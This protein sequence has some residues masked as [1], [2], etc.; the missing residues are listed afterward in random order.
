MTG[1]G[2]MHALESRLLLWAASAGA[3]RATAPGWLP[4]R[5]GTHAGAQLVERA[6]REGMAGFLYRRLKGTGRLGLL[7]DSAVRRLESI[8]YLTLRTN[9]RLL[10]VVREVFARRA[11]AVL[12]Q[13]AALLVRLYEDPG[14][15]PLTDIDLWALPADEGRV[16]AVLAQMGFRGDAKAPGLFRR[17][18]SLIDFHTH[19]LGAERIRARR[20]LL[21]VAQ[22]RIHQACRRH[23]R[24]GSAIPCLA[25]PDQVLHATYHAVKHNFERLVWLADLNHMVAGWNAADWE[26]LRQRARELGLGRLAAILCGLRREVFG[27]TPVAPAG[28]KAGLSPLARHLLRRRRSGALPA[29]SSLV[30]LSAGGPLR[31][32]A[33]ALESTLPRPGVLRQVFPE[34]AGL[35]AG[36][37]YTR[38]IRQL[39]AMLRG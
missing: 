31:Q 23:A 10:G 35:S 21:G 2:R 11:P 18:E 12:M 20:F 28:G 19:L 15:R 37:L 33:L 9:L 13:G 6:V 34:H 1:D 32:L 4:E 38:R 8:Y 29:W 14:L 3:G 30:L 25:P 27:F 26:V 16:L 22:E 7:P 39:L 24:E 17:G 5:L 36:R